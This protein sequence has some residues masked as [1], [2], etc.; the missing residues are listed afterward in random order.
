MSP[1]DVL[2]AARA[3]VEAPSPSH[4]EGPALLVA[5]RLLREAGLNVERQELDAPGR[6]N[7]LAARGR[8]RAVL[9]THLDTV[10]GQLPV[11]VE[12]GVLHGRG[13]CD[14]KGSAAAMIS[15]AAAL[16]EEGLEGFGVLFLCGEETTS[17]GAIAADALIGSGEA[18]WPVED[19]LLAEP[20]DNRFVSAHPGVLTARLHACGREAHGSQPAE[21]RSA[22]HA[23]LDALASLRGASWPTDEILGETLLNVGRLEGGSAANVIA[24]SARAEL[25]FRS[26]AASSEIEARL[27]RLVSGPCT[28]A[29]TCA[30]EPVRF[31]TPEGA[32]AEPVSFSTD[33]PFLP[34][35][36]RRWLCGPGSIR[37]AHTREERIS[38][39]ELEHARDLYR[40][41]L[42]ERLGARRDQEV[43]S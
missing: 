23:L 37:L 6:F 34:S 18:G 17:D 10:P 4:E 29:L 12:D 42:H 36:G 11:R 5:E 32:S 26:G 14:A 8:P 30:S 9:S 24:G 13:A 7:L 1:R 31:A 40:G 21:G 39:A 43:G 35:L 16:V 22:V 28:L 41:W 38:Q 20:T 15:A 33:A 25:M 2:Q 19:A 27:R 3:L